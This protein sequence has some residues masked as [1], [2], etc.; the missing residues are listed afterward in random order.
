MPALN[1]AHNGKQYAEWS[2]ES[3]EAAGIPAEVLDAAELAAA[4]K[5]MQCSRLQARL[6][7]IDAPDPAAAEDSLW[8]AIL[9]YFDEPARTAAELAYWEEART[10]RRDDPVLAAA[11]TAL[12]LDD[13]AL[14]A[15]FAD[16]MSR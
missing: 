4:R 12:G 8:D 11:A 16:A 5:G 3:A 9:A 2:R 10:W 6:A 13:P 7:L 1:F 15:L 14:D